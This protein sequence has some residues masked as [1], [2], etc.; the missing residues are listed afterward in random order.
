MWECRCLCECGGRGV[1]GYESGGGSGA[2]MGGEQSRGVCR[3]REIWGEGKERKRGIFFFDFREIYGC[4]GA[5]GE[6]VIVFR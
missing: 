3:I 1:W 6:N 5:M 4:V 2:G